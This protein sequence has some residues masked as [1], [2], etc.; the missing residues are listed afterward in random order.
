MRPDILNSYFAPI[1]GLPGIG[2][3]L[4]KPFNR[5]LARAEGARILDLLLH[6]PSSTIDRRA[7]PTLREVVPDTVVTVEVH[8]DRHVP[9]PRGSRAPYRVYAHDETGD[10]ILAF[11]KAERSWME[12]LLP[13]G[14]TR[15]VSGTVSLYDGIPQMV[16]PDR[17]VDA[18][19]LAKLPSIE[20]LYPL[21]EGLGHGHVRRAVEAA[22]AHTADL[23]EWQAGA[24]ELSFHEALRRVHQPREPL[25]ASSAGPA[26][27]RLAY[28]EL[29]AGQIAL[30]LVRA[31]TVKQAGRPSLGDGR[32]AD[33]I[34]GALPFALTG[35]QLAALEAIRADLA[36]ND[37]M[38][39]LLQGDVGSGKTVVALLAAAT[40]IEAGRQAALMAPTEILARQHMKTI[41]PLAA[42]AGL[43]VALLTG[44]EKGRARD[45]L[46]A[47]LAGGAVDLVIGTHAL[48][49]EGVTF[50]DLGLAIVD[51]QHRFGVHQR[52]A[53]ASKGEAVD[54][55]VMTATPIPRTLVLTYFGDMES[56]ELRE[57]PA[58]RKPIDTRAIP[59]DRI[60]EIV[61]RLGTAL[62]QGRRAYWICPLVEESENSDLAA[63]EARF[64]ELTAHF[65]ARVGLVHGKMKGAEKDAAMAAFA[66]GETQLLVATT[67]VEVG[68]DVPEASII[69]IEHAERFGLAQL[70]Q[71][72]GRVGRGDVASVCILLY[73][74]P[75]GEVAH[76]RLEALRSSE[77]GFFLAE[78]DLRLRGEGDVLGTRQSGFPGFRVA[79]LD[80]HGD[81]LTQARAE[82]AEIVQNDSDLSGRRGVALRLLLHIFERD[83]AVKLLGA[84]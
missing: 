5:L 64:A 71:L 15:W 83:V 57:K 7:R 82:A 42:A 79:Q 48:F 62:A 28:D 11:F 6:L 84:G 21:V 4:A 9:P 13:I 65:G 32:V 31:R 34:L 54:V 51:E 26:W 58:G 55:L 25:D 50:H 75:L 67:V 77:D 17:V 2:P 53:L 3:K 38:L 40:L 80:L 14:E 10:L 47:D 23:P 81:L 19:G 70:H 20:P 69:V 22:L 44:R 61:A 39:R 60:D 33:R 73:R 29:L 18:A 30:A 43:R 37:R 78:E 59:S 66:S 76:Q 41:A 68:V 46:L 12:R 8:V 27:R 35:S 72:R 45:Q 56:S 36:S 74:R 24:P 63:A 49:Q 1:T 52:L 16:H